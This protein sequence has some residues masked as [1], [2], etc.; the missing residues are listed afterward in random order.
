[1]EDSLTTDRYRY[2]RNAHAA[3]PNPRTTLQMSIEQFQKFRST[4][5]DVSK[6]LDSA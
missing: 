3:A 6:V 2:A 4:V 1:L 5:V